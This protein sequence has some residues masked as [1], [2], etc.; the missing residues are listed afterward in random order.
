MK[1]GEILVSRGLL[2]QDVLEK[3]LSVQKEKP[4]QRIGE[5]LLEMGALG[6]E[7][8]FS[9][10]SE[11][12]GMPFKKDFQSFFSPELVG[13]ISFDSWQRWKALPIRE[14]G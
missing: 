9:G 4:Q 6:E 5:I 2:T 12:L 10:L 7:D 8:L 13:L 14:E 11:Q 3:T 1:I